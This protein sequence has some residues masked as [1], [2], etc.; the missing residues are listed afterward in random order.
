MAAAGGHGGV[1][2][3]QAGP[4]AAGSP[5]AAPQPERMGFELCAGAGAASGGGYPFVC[6][7]GEAM[8]QMPAAAAAAG[9][10]G[11]YPEVAAEELVQMQ[12]AQLQMLQGA[13][14]L[15]AQAQAMAQAQQARHGWEGLQAAQGPGEGGD[16]GVPGG[17][18]WQA[19]MMA[20]AGQAAGPP[21]FG[22]GGLMLWVR[23]IT[24]VH[25]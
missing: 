17:W 4:H 12:L 25:T 1:G 6:G 19:A 11:A 9:G 7:A 3:G 20:A 10:D 2:F 15:Q 8:K 5:M 16:G 14:Q 22:Q 18:L 23:R 21:D 24:W 13:A